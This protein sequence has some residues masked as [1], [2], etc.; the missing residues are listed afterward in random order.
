MSR[1][2]RQRVSGDEDA[3]TVVALGGVDASVS[4]DAIAR[5]RRNDLF[6]DATVIVGQ[7]HFKTHR[8]VLAASSDF[9]QRAFENGMAESI[10]NTVTLCE[11]EHTVAAVEAC[12]DWMYTGTADVA[13]SLLPDLLA[14]ATHL[15]V[16]TLAETVKGLI[17]ERIG[18]FG[19]FGIWQ[20]G[21]RF[22]LS[23][24]IGA[25]K[26]RVQ[27]AFEEAT[28]TDDFLSAPASWLED[29]LAS[30]EIYVRSEDAV[31]H[32]LRR[33]QA[34][35]PDLPQA[36]LSHLLSLVRWPLMSRQSTD[37][38]IG[39]AATLM[40]HPDGAM[41]LLRAFQGVAYGAMPARVWECGTRSRPFMDHGHTVPFGHGHDTRVV[42]LFRHTGAC[43]VLR[44]L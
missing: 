43:P 25:A 35:Q 40:G 6:C 1:R 3:A 39:D 26:M 19:A 14:C 2:V 11:R 21:D 30:D 8:I 4:M 23:D 42:V 7:R 24:L 17:T 12:L 20:L 41:I 10:T 18:S 33:W 22:A 16:P 32:A 34:A 15:L 36:A 9:F 29:L 13:V 31:F 38:I 27:L 37:E 44:Y 5:M 28:S